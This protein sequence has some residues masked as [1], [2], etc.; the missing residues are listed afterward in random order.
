MIHGDDDRNVPISESVVLLEKLRKQGV[1]TET[2]ILPDEVHG[3]LLHSNWLK[4]YRATV[5]F[6]DRKLK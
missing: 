5:D 2:M 1:E 6:L 4:V 3:F